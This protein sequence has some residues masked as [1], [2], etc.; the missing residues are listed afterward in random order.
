MRLVFWII[1][2]LGLVQAIPKKQISIHSKYN[3]PINAQDVKLSEVDLALYQND[4]QQIGQKNHLKSEITNWMQAKT[5]LLEQLSTFYNCFEIFLSKQ[6]QIGILLVC[7]IC[8]AFYLMVKSEDR[9][10]KQKKQNTKKKQKNCQQDVIVQI[11]T[12]S[13]IAKEQSPLPQ[14]STINGSLHLEERVNKSADQ[15]KNNGQFSLF[16]RSNSQ[17]I[18]QPN[19]PDYSAEEINSLL[20]DIS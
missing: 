2:F 14:V 18:I 17:P 10:M 11:L 7:I 8:F 4:M 5:S 15:M 16:K 19:L 20:K 13:L 9:N 1:V 3:T 12:D 6:Q